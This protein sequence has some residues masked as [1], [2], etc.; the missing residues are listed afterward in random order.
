MISIQ[1]VREN[2]NAGRIVLV[3]VGADWCLTCKLNDL[4]VFDTPQTIA[5]L[6]AYNVVV[7]DVD[8]T[9]YNRDVLAFMEKFGRR[10]LPFTWCSR[11]GFRTEW[12]CR[13]SSA[14]KIL[15]H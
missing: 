4:N 6:D 13:N 11:P 9:N 12:Y 1:E 10:G 15:P 7:L 8:W 14:T 3:R 2:V 5:L